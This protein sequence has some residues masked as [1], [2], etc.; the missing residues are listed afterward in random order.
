MA[1]PT[2]R[3]SLLTS[4]TFTVRSGAEPIRNQATEPVAAAA[5]SAAMTCSSQDA[6]LTLL[7]GVCETAA[8]PV[9]D[10]ARLGNRWRGLN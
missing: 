8:A 1:S 7:L 3:Y 4:L 10:A 9:S 5:P 2:T 6:P